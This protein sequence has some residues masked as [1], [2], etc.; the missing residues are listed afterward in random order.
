MKMMPPF[1]SFIIPV[2]NVEK[3]LRQCLDSVL[4][5]SFYNWE[6]ILVDDGSID[7]SANICDEYTR[8]DKRFKVIHKSNGG[9]SSARNVG[10]AYANA[11][12]ITFVDADD[13]ISNDYLEHAYALLKDE[14]TH[15]VTISA[16][17]MSDEGEFLPYTS[18]RDEE[19]PVTTYI[20]KI[21][22]FISCCYFFRLKIIVDNK[23]EF[24]T[25]LSMSEDAVFVMT[26]FQ[27]ISSIYT[28]SARKYFYR[29]NPNSATGKGVDYNKSLNHY[30]AAMKI[31]F[32]KK[33]QRLPNS[34]I[35]FAVKYQLR[36]FFSEI[37]KMDLKDEDYLDVQG[38]VR[39]LYHLIDK[40]EQ[41]E[42][43]G[44]AAYSVRFYNMAYDYLF[45]LRTKY[46]RL[47]KFLVKIL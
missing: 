10:I 12:W 42:F 30:R 47:K 3:Y 32:L 9:V 4:F 22:H 39:E 7:G 28:C 35:D 41:P 18:F 34:A 20:N 31:H 24:D 36:M 5:Q 38:K 17:R 25:S 19:I 14:K 44:I 21:T 6:C 8:K 2:Y 15:T 1:V 45:S 16:V 27:Y 26:Y 11:R 29:L 33:N 23:I 43:I 46:R 40:N 37:R 13:I